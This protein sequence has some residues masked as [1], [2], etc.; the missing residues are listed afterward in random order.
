M[1]QPRD[2][3]SQREVCH[4]QSVDRL[5][6][7]HG[8]GFGKDNLRGAVVPGALSIKRVETFRRRQF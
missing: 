4:P 1:R 3:I 6:I 7:R 5:Q 8:A 2:Q